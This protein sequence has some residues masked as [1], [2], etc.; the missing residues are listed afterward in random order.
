MD[1]DKIKKIMHDGLTETMVRAGGEI[2]EGTD[3]GK[4]TE[5][6]L[7]EIFKTQGIPYTLLSLKTVLE[8]MKCLYSLTDDDKPMLLNK[9][10]TLMFTFLIYTVGKK[11]KEVKEQSAKITESNV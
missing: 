5:D 10:Q 1:A 4:A 2:F 9:N 7:R 3:I 6:T 8:G 11:E